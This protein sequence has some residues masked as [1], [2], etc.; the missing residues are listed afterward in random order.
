[1]PLRFGEFELDRERRQLLSAGQPVPL[2]PK[3]YEFLSLLVERR[4]RALSRGQ[5]RGVVWPGTFVNESTL[6]WG[7][8][9]PISRLSTFPDH[10]YPTFY[11]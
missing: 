1:M 3:A 10:E 7:S 8:T 6:G 11:V 4:P 5:I 9:I 2:E